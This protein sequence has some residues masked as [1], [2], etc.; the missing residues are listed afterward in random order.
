[1][2]KERRGEEGRRER[3]GSIKVYYC[4]AF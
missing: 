2:D 1:M 4:N 3:S